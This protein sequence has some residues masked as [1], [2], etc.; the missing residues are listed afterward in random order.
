VQFRPIRAE[1]GGNEVAPEGTDVVKRARP[2]N[3]S[4]GWSGS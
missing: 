3:L 2:V 1:G 4:V